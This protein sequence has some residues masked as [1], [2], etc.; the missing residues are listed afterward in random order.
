MLAKIRPLA[1][2]LTVCSCAQTA[3]PVI[4]CPQWPE[5]TPEERSD[6]RDRVPVDSAAY[7]WLE[8]LFVLK[9]ELKACEEQSNA[10]N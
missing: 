4:Y 9:T 3:T 2:L 10:E 5:L 7:G 8:R 6:L 1:I